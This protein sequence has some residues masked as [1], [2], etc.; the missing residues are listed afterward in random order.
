MRSVF[1]WL[2][3]NSERISHWA[4]AFAFFAAAVGGF[5]AFGQLKIAN[6]QFEQANDQRRWQNYNEM[7]VRYAELYKT[8]PA[9]IASGC[10]PEEFQKLEAETKRWVRQYF[11]LYSEEYWL[12]VN[13]LIPEEMWT[14]RIHRGVRVNLSKYPALIDGYHYW[15]A[16]GSF[17]HPDD[18]QTVVEAAI[19]DAK[20]PKYAA[21]V[22]GSC[23]PRT[24]SNTALQ[25]ALR[26]T[27][28]Q[29]P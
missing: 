17:T 2:W 10:A 3:I 19:A 11:D 1:S 18:F 14:R 15:K 9:D 12:F 6:A 25:G 4:T 20:S 26:Q 5:L 28:V 22:N 21:K 13:K 29:R 7:N 27:A 8:I 16:A 24:A 23:T